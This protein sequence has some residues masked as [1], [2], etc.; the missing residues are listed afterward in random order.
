MVPTETEVEKTPAAPVAPP[1]ARTS[2]ETE[3]HAR[4]LDAEAILKKNPADHEARHRFQQAISCLESLGTKIPQS[5]KSLTMPPLVQAPSGLKLDLACGQS[6]KEGFDGVD[7]RAPGVKHKLDLLQFPW[8]WADS[9]VAE[10]HCSHFVEHIPAD[11]VKKGRWAGKDLFFAFFDEIYRILVPKG[12]ATIVVPFLR[13]SRAF[14][15]PTHRRFICHETFGYLSADWRKANKLD[16]YDVECDFGVN[17]I[18][19]MDGGELLRAPEA[20]AYRMGHYWN[21]AMD[22][23]A[24]LIKKERA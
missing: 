17:V 3:L 10:I 1:P 14:Q 23:H 22:L 21:V 7:L 8:P 15:D 2:L 12:V 20:Q 9:T 24:T 16:H 5:I 6:C 13:S 19:S 18:H 11:V 4:L